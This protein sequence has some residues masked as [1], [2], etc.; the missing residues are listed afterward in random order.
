MINQ[1]FQSFWEFVHALIFLWLSYLI[2]HA[3]WVS[4]LSY[5][6]AFRV[7]NVENVDGMVSLW[8]IR[9]QSWNNLEEKETF[10]F[11]VEKKK[12]KRI[13]VKF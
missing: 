3:L 11:C 12:K 9:K 7:D 5:L 2:V 6:S 8:Q 4:W 10:S 13:R 1:G